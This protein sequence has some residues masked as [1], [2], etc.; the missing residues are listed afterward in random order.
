MAAW[1]LA[2]A[3]AAGCTIVL[4]PSSSTS[5]SLTIFQGQQP[6]QS[7]HAVNFGKRFTYDAESVV[8]FERKHAGIQRGKRQP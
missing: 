6:C 7:L 8:L 1:K 5:L 3:L 4:K 2:P